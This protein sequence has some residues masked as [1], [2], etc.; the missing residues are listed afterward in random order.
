MS[1]TSS[2]HKKTAKNQA[3]GTGYWANAWFRLKKNK[4]AMISLAVLILMVLIAIF[5][6]IVSPYPYDLQNADHAFQTPSKQH[7]LGTDNF[8]RDILSRIIHGG[9]ISLLVGFSSIIFAIILGGLLGA[10]SGYYAGAVDNIIMRSMDILMA[11]P[12]MLLA[13][14]LAAAFEPGLNNVIIAI[15]V[16]EVPIYARVIRSSV[17]TI[18]GQEFIEAAESIGASDAR[19][20]LRHIIPNCMAP[21]IVQATLGMA[22]AILSVAALSFLGLG[23]QP[24]TPEWGSMLA[25]VRQHLTTYPHMAVFPGLAIMITIFALNILGDGLRDALDPRLKN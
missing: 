13:I 2:K 17:L 1:R 15:G 8:G 19:I 6:D 7:L 20:I 14:T 9:R 25:N 12:G 10:L 3:S 4:G 22:G 11:I 5:A 23:I 21:I 16:A 18:K 24:P